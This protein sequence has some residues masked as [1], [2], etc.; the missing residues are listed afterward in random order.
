MLFG[1]FLVKN[2]LNRFA[3]GD[4]DDLQYNSDGSLDLFI[5][6]Q[7]PAQAP[8]QNWLPIPAAGPF[9]LTLR[10]YWPKQQVLDGNWRIPFV[11]PV[12]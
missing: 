6:T 9:S 2:D 5:Q 4:R 7:Q 12:E 8:M 1:E 11:V 10:L 3:L